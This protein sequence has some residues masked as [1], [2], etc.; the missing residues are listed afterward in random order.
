MRKKEPVQGDTPLRRSTRLQPEK[1]EEQIPKELQGP[2]D[3][4][5]P[6]E[7][8]RAHRKAGAPTEDPSL[9]GPPSSVLPAAEPETQKGSGRRALEKGTPFLQ[10]ANV[11]QEVETEQPPQWRVPEPLWPSSIK[12]RPA[13]QESAARLQSSGANRESM[14][15]VRARINSKP[16]ART[17]KETG[18]SRSPAEQTGRKSTKR[19]RPLLALC[20]LLFLPIVGFASWFVWKHGSPLPFLGLMG[21]VP[22]Q[23]SSFP[24]LWRATEECSSQCSVMLVESI[25][26]ILNYGPGAP[27]HLSTYQA[28]MNLLAGANNS[29]EIAA[30]YFTLRDSDIHRDD[31]SSQQGKEVFESLLALPSQGVKLNIAV[32][33]PEMSESDTEELSRQGANVWK[34]DMKRLTGGIVHTKLWVVDGKHVY[35][36]SA[37]MD[38]RALT[39]VK[40][41]GAVLHN[42]SCLARDLL[43]IFATYR[44]LGREGASLPA[45][46]PSSLA[47]ESSLDHPLKLQLDG[48][49]AE[50]YISSS[51]PALSTQGRTAD[52]TAIV[53]TIEDAQDFVYIS[54]MDYEPQCVFC[55]PKSY[56]PVIDDAL[57]TAA[58]TRRV[59]VRLLISCWQHSSGAMFIFLESLNILSRRPLECPIEVRLFAF[60]VDEDLP[61]IPYTH[62]NH[63]KYMVTDRLAYIGT[64]N[65]SED[66][67]TRTAGVGLIVNQSQAADG[68]SGPTLR[69]Q[70]E[71]VFYR[72]WDSSYTVPLKEHW[73]CSRRN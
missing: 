50:V 39:Q 44:I 23:L 18:A 30:F 41:L 1:V 2:S 40:E 43:R 57:R 9:A 63:N 29:V 73:Q 64:S 13:M 37:N 6:R 58:C 19:F 67:F 56:W 26:D 71:N 3:F 8:I 51:P 70:L 45:A 59:K 62:V 42:C 68:D 17:L 7:S 35:V 12:A 47:A 38:W 22:W 14:Q 27:H 21:Y 10:R 49:G 52:L 48:I 69:Q 11:E 32:N 5:Q 34:V 16:A 53:S 31:P 46:W 65:W 33:S 61:P 66:Y 15:P 72:D 36:G 60:P 54:V 25:P 4:L 20:I 24:R 28:W 55:D